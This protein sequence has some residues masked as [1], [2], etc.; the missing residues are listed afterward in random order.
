MPDR[1]DGDQPP[2]HQSAGRSEAVPDLQPDDEGYKT[3]SGGDL[4]DQA[5]YLRWI[6]GGDEKDSVYRND[7][8]AGRRF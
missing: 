1:E 6:C 5:E 3:G 4:Y 2:G 7:H 8:R